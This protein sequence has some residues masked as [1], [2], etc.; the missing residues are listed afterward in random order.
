MIISL[1]TA[2]VLSKEAYKPIIQSVTVSPTEIVNGGVV[3]FTVIAKSNAPVN[4]LS[5]R[6]MG[7]RGSIS[8]GVTRVTFTNV[9]DDLWK[10]EWTHT[11]SEWEPIGT[12]TYSREF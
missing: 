3:T 7:P 1:L 8:R 12:Y 10:C 5:R 2:S 11:I 4:A 6:V 9:G